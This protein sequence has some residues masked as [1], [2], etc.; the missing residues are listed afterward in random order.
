VSHILCVILAREHS[1]TS[2]SPS[3]H[4]HTLMDVLYILYDYG[5]VVYS[6]LYDKKMLYSNTY[7]VQPVQYVQ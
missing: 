1:P 4:V 7:Q 3:R 6:V 2:L 5:T